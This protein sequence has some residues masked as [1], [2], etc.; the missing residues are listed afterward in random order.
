MYK[1]KDLDVKVNY[2][3]EEKEFM[4][5]INV[6]EGMFE[7][8]LLKFALLDRRVNINTRIAD[9][10]Y[11]FK[12]NAFVDIFPIENFL[13]KVID[14]LNLVDDFNDNAVSPIEIYS[15]YRRL[16]E[17]LELL[18]NRVKSLEDSNW[19]YSQPIPVLPSLDWY[20][21]YDLVIDNSTYQCNNKAHT[22]STICLDNEIVAKKEDNQDWK[23]ISSPEKIANIIQSEAASLTSDGC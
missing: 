11:Y 16:E 22:C 1:L 2:L 15:K 19:G 10:V 7:K 8:D 5:K 12:E 3:Q 20:E 23:I 17:Q 4:I 13:N 14:N 9:F 6:E 21:N 18:E